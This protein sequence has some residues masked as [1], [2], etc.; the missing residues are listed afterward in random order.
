MGYLEHDR[1]SEEVLRTQCGTNLYASQ[2]GQTPMGASRSQVPR[3][4]YKK[5]WETVLDK[6]GEKILPKQSGDYGLASQAGEVSFGKVE[7]EWYSAIFRCQWA[8]SF[9][10]LLFKKTIDYYLLIVTLLQDIVT[11]CP[12][13]V[14]VCQMIVELMVCFA[15]N[16]APIFLLLSRECK[17]KLQIVV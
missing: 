2:K 9:V 17:L 15:I 4:T 5:D 10:I 1:R 8:V 14:A 3:V 16:L 6:E 7:L 13:F 12:T 11:K